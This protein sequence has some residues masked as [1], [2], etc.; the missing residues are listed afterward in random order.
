MHDCATVTVLPAVQRAA[1]ARPVKPEKPTNWVISFFSVTND[2]SGSSREAGGKSLIHLGRS[3]SGVNPC[4]NNAEGWIMMIV[5]TTYRSVVRVPPVDMW[6]GGFP[7][8]IAH[9]SVTHNRAPLSFQFSPSCARANRQISSLS[10]LL[11]MRTKKLSVCTNGAY[12]A[13]KLL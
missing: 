7:G 8:C 3:E 10:P 5:E 12:F 11:E 13:A 2:E 9:P 1:K 4:E 6:V